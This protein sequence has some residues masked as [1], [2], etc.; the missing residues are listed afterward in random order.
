MAIHKS[1]LGILS[2]ITIA[3]AT[4]TAQPAAAAEAGECSMVLAQAEDARSS[5]EALTTAMEQGVAD[6]AAWVQRTDEINSELAGMIG[7]KNEKTEQLV[8]ERAEIAQELR[9]LD[10]LHP[11]LARQSEA[12]RTI[13]DETERAYIACI[14]ASI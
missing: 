11:K 8:R 5:L 4:L 6:R 1:F 2:G 10:Q 13:V 3:L 14:E 7:E 9:V 12:L